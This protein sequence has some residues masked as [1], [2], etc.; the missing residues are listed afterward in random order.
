MT[1]RLALPAP[2]LAARARAAFAVSPDKPN[3][4]ALA[5]LAV[6]SATHGLTMLIID[7]LTRP[8][9]SIDEMIERVLSTVAQG[10]VARIKATDSASEG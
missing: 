6:W 2:G 7:H 1:Y 5:A 8:D 10:L 3:D 9:L 4:L